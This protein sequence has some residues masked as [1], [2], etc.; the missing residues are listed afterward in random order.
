M[1]DT[2]PPLEQPGQPERPPQPPQPEDAPKAGGR[3]RAALDRLVPRSRGARWAVLGAAVVIVGG[4]AAAVAVSE[5]HHGRMD[6]GPRLAWFEDG[7]EGG[8]KWGP[9]GEGE[10]RGGPPGGGQGRHDGPKVRDGLDGLKGLDGGDARP[11]SPKNAPAPLPS[12]SI[13]A[14]ADKAAAAVP[15]G[16]VESLRVVAQEGGGSAWRAVVLGPDGVRHAVT[17]SG[18]DGTVTD[19][20]TPAGR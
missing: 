4:G 17:V 1:S 15:G 3:G 20:T 7:H 10:R 12:L 18:T 16:K 9:V 11:G 2:F 14:A 5:H 19:N 6:R 8:G 13:G